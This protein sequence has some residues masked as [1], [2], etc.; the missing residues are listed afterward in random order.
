[1][2]SVKPRGRAGRGPLAAT[3][4]WSV[5]ATYALVGAANQM[6]WLTFTPITTPAA[7]HYG[8]SVN[9]IGW[10]AEIFPLLYVVLG[11]SGRVAARSLVPPGAG[12]RR[13]ADGDRRRGAAGR[14]HV[15][16]GACRPAAD[17]H[18]PAIDSER[19]HRVGE[20]LP[21]RALAAGRDRD[22]LGRDLPRDAAVA[23]AGLGDRR[24]PPPHAARDRCC[25]RRRGDGGDA[26]GVR[27]QPRDEGDRAT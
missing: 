16:L 15:R 21:G 14:R 12:R 10:L 24:R 5:I 22:R 2:L 18:R 7:H 4:R 23:G 17:R 1:M 11:G 3:D 27:A 25:V 19:R 13:G 26:G 6:L 9:D 8:V 20:R